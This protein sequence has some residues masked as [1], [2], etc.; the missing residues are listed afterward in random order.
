[1]TPLQVLTL[2]TLL[3][4]IKVEGFHHGD[5]IG[6]DFQAHEVAME[7]GIPIWLHPPENPT[8]RAF[9]Q[10]ALVVDDTYPYLIRNHHIVEQSE[11]LIAGPHEPDMVTR[12]GTWATV[13][14]AMTL[15]RDIAIL[16]P[17]GQIHLYGPQGRFGQ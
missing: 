9:C 2:H 10:G 5:C 3:E 6:A 15:S 1:M 7:L 12:S 8:K 13:R 17:D 11:W 14:Y 4:D 16:L